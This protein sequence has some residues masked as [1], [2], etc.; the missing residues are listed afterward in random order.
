MQCRRERRDVQSGLWKGKSQEFGPGISKEG[1]SFGD[2]EV[3]AYHGSRG[4]QGAAL[5]GPI[6]C[7]RSA[8]GFINEFGVCAE[9]GGCRSGQLKDCSL[10]RLDQVVIHR[11]GYAGCRL[12]SSVVRVR[13][14]VMLLVPVSSVVSAAIV[15]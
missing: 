10:D 5:K 14:V 11:V 8:I 9:A 13:L 15:G 2:A 7:Q 6:L 12:G 1:G 3:G 4:V